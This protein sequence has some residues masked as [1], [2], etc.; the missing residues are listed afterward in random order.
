MDI[1]VSSNGENPQYAGLDGSKA[2]LA[3]F[4]PLISRF[5]C[6]QNPL[7]RQRQQSPPQLKETVT[8]SP[9]DRSCTRHQSAPDTREESLCFTSEGDVI[10]KERLPLAEVLVP[11]PTQE[12]PSQAIESLTSSHKARRSTRETSPE[13]PSD[14]AEAEG[15]ESE[16]Q[17]VA[18]VLRQISSLEYEEKLIFTQEQAIVMRIPD[19]VRLLGKKLLKLRTGRDLVRMRSTSQANLEMDTVFESCRMLKSDMVR[20]LLL[21]FLRNRLVSPGCKNETIP[22]TWDINDPDEVYDILEGIDK[23]TSDFAI[24]Q[25]FGQMK[26]VDLVDV[27][28]SKTPGLTCVAVLHE[29]ATRKA[30]RVSQKEVNSKINKYTTEYHIGRKWHNVVSCFGGPGTVL[31]FVVAGMWNGSKYVDRSSSSLS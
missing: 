28:A 2:T 25:A 31:I 9:E 7:V 19:T 6:Q 26:L 10:E 15:V 21:E 3:S 24:H 4:S 30:G 5:G 22:A 17:S 1:G 20:E 18:K 29:L 14:H 16:H 11:E 13:S 12:E 27:K 23:E 8:T